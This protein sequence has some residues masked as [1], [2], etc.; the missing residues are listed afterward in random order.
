MKTAQ[1]DFP[2]NAR[3]DLLLVPVVMEGMLQLEVTATV[4]QID[5][6]CDG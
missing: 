3:D 5:E 6:L 1:L 4:A 2:I